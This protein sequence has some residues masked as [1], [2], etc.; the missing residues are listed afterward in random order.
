MTTRGGVDTYIITSHKNGGCFLCF[1]D[2]KTDVAIQTQ[3]SVKR[4]EKGGGSTVMVVD[5]WVAMYAE[6]LRAVV[7]LDTM[8]IDV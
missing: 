1:T 6:G 4:L 2:N 8:T 5:F 7:Q 3:H